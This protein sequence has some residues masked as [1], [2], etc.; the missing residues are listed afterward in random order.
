M[1]LKC[2]MGG[3]DR[4]LRILIGFVLIYISLANTGLVSS[5]LLRYILSIIG[6]INIVSSIISFCPIYILA[7]I[8]TQRQKK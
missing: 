2:N 4:I 8:S 3:F 1:A 6:V 7:N 5:L